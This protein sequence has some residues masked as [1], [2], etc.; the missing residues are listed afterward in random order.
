MVYGCGVVP[1]VIRRQSKL[2]EHFNVTYDAE[3][4]ERIINIVKDHILLLKRV[5]NKNWSCVKCKSIH[6]RSKYAQPLFQTVMCPR[7]FIQY[8]QHT[9]MMNH[10]YLHR[11][12]LTFLVEE[13]L[14]VPSTPEL[15]STLYLHSAKCLHVGDKVYATIYCDANDQYM[16]SY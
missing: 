12:K 15:I 6:Q 14:A 8:K 7:C 2:S 3:E 13:L 10:L 9:T 1:I 4:I 11:Q 16:L 5:K